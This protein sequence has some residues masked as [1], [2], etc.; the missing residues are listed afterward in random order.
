M[1]LKDAIVQELQLKVPADWHASAVVSWQGGTD[2][3]QGP[4]RSLVLTQEPLAKPCSAE[5][6]ARRQ[7]E[8][9]SQKLPGFAQVG[10]AAVDADVGAMPVVVFE[11]RSPE[12][13]AVVR[14]VQAFLVVGR[15]AWTLTGT[16]SGALPE[17][18]QPAF[19]EIAATLALAGRPPKRQLGVVP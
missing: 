8:A 15:S 3:G 19:T 17:Q 11:W 16:S 14:Q 9:L 2:K 10:Q 5:E 7:V 18:L 12:Q 13:D 4:L 1:S 6:Y